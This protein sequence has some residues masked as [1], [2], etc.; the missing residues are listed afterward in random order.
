MI[1]SRL[2]VHFLVKP[3]KKGEYIYIRTS[4]L[5]EGGGQFENLIITC[6]V[7]KKEG[8]KVNGYYA[9]KKCI[10]GAVVG[11]IVITKL[12]HLFICISL[13]NFSTSKHEFW[14]FVP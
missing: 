1:E 2:S 12:G 14:V 11:F 4:D 10:L 3:S 6:R 7:F 8:V 5:K 9:T 13:N